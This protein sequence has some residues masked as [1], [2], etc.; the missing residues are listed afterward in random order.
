[1][2]KLYYIT[3]AINEEQSKTSGFFKSF[4]EAKEALEG[5]HDWYRSIGTGCI[6]FK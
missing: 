4:D 1:M 6:W 3:N 5:C 2:D